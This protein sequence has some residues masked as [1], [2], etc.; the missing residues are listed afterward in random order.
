MVRIKR[1]SDGTVQQFA[2]RKLRRLRAEMRI[3][4]R[5]INAE[6]PDARHRRPAIRN[7]DVNRVSVGDRDYARRGM[8]V[9]LPVI[10][11]PAK[12][13]ELIGRAQREQDTDG[14]TENGAA[15]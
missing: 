3:K 9:T 1:D 13:A 12:R 4:T 14:A 5:T 7:V 6:Q 15:M 10:A 8:V 11:A 2:A